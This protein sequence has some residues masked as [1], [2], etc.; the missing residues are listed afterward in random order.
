MLGWILSINFF[1]SL[2]VLKFGKASLNKRINLKN[3]MPEKFKTHP[4]I[5]N[6]IDIIYIIDLQILL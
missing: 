3:A 1:Q 5:K 6:I 2:L 4:I